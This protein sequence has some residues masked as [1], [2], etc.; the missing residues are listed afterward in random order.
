L[1]SKIAV[2]AAFSLGF[3]F[4]SS[5]EKNTHVIPF[6]REKN[7]SKDSYHSTNFLANSNYVS[8]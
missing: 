1:Q 6:Q 5:A 2:D 8:F 4:S 7:N 3:L